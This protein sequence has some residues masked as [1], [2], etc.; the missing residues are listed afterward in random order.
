MRNNMPIK[1]EFK[2]GE[3][4]VRGVYICMCCSQDREEVIEIPNDKGDY[5]L[6][7]C[8]EHGRTGWYLM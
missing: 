3:M 5:I 7:C 1:R 8:P 2:T 4:G 6:P